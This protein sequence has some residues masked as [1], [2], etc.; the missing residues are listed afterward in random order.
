MSFT[1]DPGVRTETA[2]EAGSCN[3]LCV[4]GT[5]PIEMAYHGAVAVQR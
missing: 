5:E 1:I 3:G 4:A 2:I